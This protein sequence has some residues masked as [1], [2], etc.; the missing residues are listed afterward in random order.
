MDSRKGRRSA[1]LGPA[2]L[3]RGATSRSQGLR[4]LASAAARGRH[5]FVRVMRRHVALLLVASAAVL[6]A[7]AP[8]GAAVTRHEARAIA[9]ADARDFVSSRFRSNASYN[10]WGCRREARRWTCDLDASSEVGLSCSWTVWIVPVR[11]GGHAQ[12]RSDVACARE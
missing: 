8:A 4:R 7:P 2:V 12:G 9:R 10:L 3:I 6:A 11:A 5:T 1:S